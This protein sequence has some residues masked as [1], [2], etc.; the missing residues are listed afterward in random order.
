MQEVHIASLDERKLR[1]KK[2]KY[3]QSTNSYLPRNFFVSVLCGSRGTGKTYAAVHLLKLYETYGFKNDEDMRVLLF[4]PTADANPIYKSL[5]YLDDDDI[6]TNYSDDKLVAV[7]D[8]IKAQKEETDEYKRLLNI[9]LKFIKS[10]SLKGFTLEELN[11]LEKLDYSPPKPPKY[12]N[13]VVNYLLFD[14]LIN[15]P[16]FKTTGSKSMINHLV[17]RNRHVSCNVLILAQ[18]LKSVPKVIRTNTSLYV[19]FKFANLKIIEE[20]YDEVSSYITIEDFIKAFTYST[21]EDHDFFVIDLTGDKSLRFR[22]CW[23][24]ILDVD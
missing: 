9:Y 1:F 18:S 13:G 20:L 14:D 5:K 6:Y 7:L 12:P 11:D 17:I 23:N 21:K 2:K 3:P 16:A 4:C 10:R 19:L 22:R 24:H 8:E 15:T